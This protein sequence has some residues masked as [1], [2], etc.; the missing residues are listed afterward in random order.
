MFFISGNILDFNMKTVEYKI[1]YRPSL[2][3]AK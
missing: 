1:L 3:R 2:N